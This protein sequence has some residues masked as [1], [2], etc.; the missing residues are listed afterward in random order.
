MPW[1]ET[2]PPTREHRSVGSYATPHNCI[3]K[4]TTPMAIRA[5]CRSM[6]LSPP[7]SLPYH[8]QFPVSC[9][10]TPVT[11]LLFEGMTANVKVSGVG[12]AEPGPLWSALAAADAGW[13]VFPCAPGSK[14]PA[15]RQN[16]Q[17]LA[18]TDQG[19]IRAWWARQPYNVGIACG[20]S[21]LVVIDLDVAREQPGGSDGSGHPAGEDLTAPPPA[22]TR[23]SG[24]A[25]P[26]ASATRPAPTPSTPRP[27][28]A[29]CTS[30]RPTRRCGTRPGGSGR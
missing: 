29:T 25:R 4:V 11:R 12:R 19:R 22:P 16:W 24:C 30:P 10:R 20:P 8:H 6:Q 28:E 26:T 3:R 13:H 14:R 17:D 18:T 7:P 5:K 15:L 27:V 23:S 1:R 2:V 21:G 9:Y